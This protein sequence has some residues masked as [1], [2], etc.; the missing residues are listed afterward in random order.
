M[1]AIDS[2]PTAGDLARFEAEWN[3]HPGLRS[4]GARLDLSTEGVV[5][6]VVD[7]VEPQHRGGMG[8]NA[9][10]GAVMAGLF[11]LVIGLTGYMQAV[12]QRVGVAQ[13]NIQFMRPVNGDRLE[14]TGKAVRTGK[15]LV[16]ASAEL[17]DE[18]EVVCA[19]CDGIVAIGRGEPT[20]P[21]KIPAL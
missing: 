15:S 17:R 21:S 1:T 10:N 6:A 19:R 14:V 16:F 3:D 7:P 18:R 2:N 4:L 13:L 12:G 9:V 5:R 11:D 20:G 8:T